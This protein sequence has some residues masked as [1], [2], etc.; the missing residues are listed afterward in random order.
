MGTIR[1]ADIKDA[2][3]ILDIYKPYI[4]DTAITFEYDV[5]TLEEFERRIT[6]TRKT[7]PYLVFEEN[8][9]ILGYAYAGAA[10]ERAAYQWTCE[11]SIYIRYDMHGRGIGGKLYTKLFEYL[12]LQNIKIMYAVITTPNPQSVKF[13]EH[14]GFETIAVFRKCGYKL[15]EWRDVTWMELVVGGFESEPE[16][17]LAI[18]DIVNI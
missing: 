17:L 15:G 10:R 13:H 2:K 3:D 14:F 11:L 7:Y 12:K 6:E 8:G 16:P 5:P 4:N 18:N 1:F 9:N